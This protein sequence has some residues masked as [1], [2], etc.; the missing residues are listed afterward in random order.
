MKTFVCV[1]FFFFELLFGQ[2]PNIKLNKPG[3]ESPEEV[4]ITINPINPLNIAAGANIDLYYY[5]MDGGYTWEEGKLSSTYG[6]WGDPCVTFDPYGYLFYSHLSNPPV[7]GFWIDRI[8]VQKSIDGGV[9][10]DDGVGIGYT[11]PRKQ[12]DKEWMI[13]DHTESV[14]RGNLYLAWTEFDKY[15]SDEP[16]DSSR[17]LFSHSSDKGSNWS[18]PVIVSDRSG[19]CLD[20]DNTDEGAVPAVGP[21]GEIYLSW[22]GPLG[23]MFDKSLDGGKTFGKDIFVTNQPGGWDFNVPGINRCNGLPVTLCDISNSSYRGTIYINWS[24]QRNGTDNT[25]IFIIRSTNG[26]V[27]WSNVIKVNKDS[28][29]RHQFFSW[30]AVD[31]K[32]GIIYVVYYDRRNTTGNLTDVYLAKSGDGGESFSEF[33]VSNS[34]FLPTSNVFF[35]DYTN[36]AAYDGMI[37]PIWT[38]LDTTKLSIW[39][40]IINEKQTDVKEMKIIKTSSYSLDNNFPNPFNPST[41]ISYKIKE[42]S[43]VKLKV[44]NILGEVIKDLVNVFNNPGSFFVTWDGKNNSGFEVSSGIYFYRIEAVNDKEKF[45]DTKKM[46]LIR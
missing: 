36:I 3:T 22:G 1:F 43:M 35:G 26:G 28:T 2:Y 25:D 10:F 16:A 9:S 34:S 15:G 11:P 40:T 39:T 13:A 42:P 5:S 6:V 29:N 31:P 30:A 7:N 21:N 4:T 19:N 17:I 37:Y 44:Y 18:D 38:R 20:G 23:I 32:T 12:Q 14:F 46:V 45:I 41:V 33:K 24:D 27:T 8:V